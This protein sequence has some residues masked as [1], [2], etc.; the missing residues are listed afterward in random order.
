MEGDNEKR[1]KEEKDDDKTPAIERY[2]KINLIYDSKHS[3]Q[4]YHGFK[5]IDNLSFESKHS[6]LIKFY[7]DLEKF[8]RLDPQKEHIKAKKMIVH[9]VASK[10]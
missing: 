6:F 2:N 1:N 10:L 8:N 4:K 9:D 3:S 7:Y 5:K